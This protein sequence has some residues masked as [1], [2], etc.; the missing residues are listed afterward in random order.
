MR[1]VLQ[2][3]QHRGPAVDFLHQRVERRFARRFLV[4]ELVHEQRRHQRTGDPVVRVPAVLPRLHRLAVPFPE[5]AGELLHSGIE[6]LG[7]LEHLVVVVVLGRDP[8][9]PRLDPHVDVLA[10]QDHVAL[11]VQMLQMHDDRE[12]LV[13]GLAVRER[14]RQHRSDHLGL[15]VELAA[16]R[17]ARLGV[18]RDALGDSVRHRCHELVK[19]AR[20]LPRVARDFAH[21]F[22]VAVEL[23]EREDRQIDVVLFEP[24]EACGVVHQHVRVEHEELAGQLEAGGRAGLAGGFD[25]LAGNERERGGAGLAL[26]HGPPGRRTVR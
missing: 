5:V 11:R 14:G 3:L 13:V 6:K 17:T 18:E 20:R 9:R 15:Q 4:D 26:D 10:H 12:D 21:A 16:R 24:E 1:V 8:Q 7:V 22:L 23:L 25:G 19:K 2:R